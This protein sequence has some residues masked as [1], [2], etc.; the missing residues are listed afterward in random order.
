M[1]RG[2][3]CV[4]TMGVRQDVGFALRVLRR[5]PAFALIVIFTLALGIGAGSAM[6]SIIH[7]LLV[8]PFDFPQLDRL[9]VIQVSDN[10]GEFDNGVSPRAFLDYRADAQSFENVAAFQYWDVPVSGSGEPEQ[11]LAYQVSPG[12]FDIFSVKPALGRWFAPDE[13]DGQKE[14]VV[15]LSHGLWDRRYG[16]D[17]A[18][19]GKNIIVAG[20]SYAVVGVM[21]ADFRFPNG[22]ELWAP[23]TLTPDQRKDRRSQYL[24]VVAKLKPGASLETANAEMRQ[25]GERHAAAYTEDAK[26]SLRVVSLVRGVTEDYTR[27][28]IFILLGASVFLLLI[29]CANVANLFLAHALARRKE[30]AVRTALG[31]GRSRIVRQLLTEAAVLGVAGGVLALLFA[32]WAVDLVKAAMPRATVRFIPGWDSMGVEPAV[33]AFSLGLGFL[34]G[35]IFGVVPALQVSRTDVNSVLK[36]G[37]RGTTSGKGT[38]RL[39]AALV[40]AQISLA[41]VLLLG[42]GAMVKGFVRMANPARGLDGANVLTMRVTLPQAR[43]AKPQAEIIEFER[44]V[45]ERMRALPGVEG[46]A[47]VNN[48]PW[49]NNGNMRVPFPEGRV[50]RTEDEIPV[51]YRPATPGY[52][53]LLRVPRIEGRG[54]E[55]RDGA[56]APRVALL[57]AKAAHQIWPDE[58]PIGKRFRWAPD[59]KSPWITVVGVVGDIRDRIDE[60]GPRAAVWV[61]FVQGA[62]ATMYF[63]LRTKA[64]PMAMAR[65]AAQTVYAVDPNQPVV[66]MRTLDMVLSE[67]LSG[68]RIGT[69]MMGGFALLALILAAVGIYGVVATLVTQRTHEIGVRMALGAQR[70]DVLRLIMRRGVILT[71]VGVILGFGM[72]VGLVRFLDSVLVNA[73]DNDAIVFVTFTTVVVMI[74]MFGTLVPAWRATNV[75]P[76]QALRQD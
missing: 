35:L 43:E 29:A 36:D 27:N 73:V 5:K 60:R 48:V 54:I 15:I 16:R 32:S 59:D 55:D 24:G 23:I 76:L 51:D 14:N 56:A 68:F 40:I 3:L 72:G 6:F 61:P 33:L 37:D 4:S 42:A 38:H 39:R 20:A 47:A 25:M 10:G 9:A 69:S 71:A 2:S 58:S 62:T 8:R 18:I 30:L 64:E 70:G 13:I 45:L 17:P 19:V 74:A 49:G 57:S 21:P 53:E 7:A 65:A 34:V 22:G 46:A 1:A 75:D 66:A 28:F 52:L 44:A 50:V 11:V 41:L 67:R 31:A 26:R 63:A 12:F